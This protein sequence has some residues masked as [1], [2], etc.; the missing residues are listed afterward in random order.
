[1]SNKFTIELDITLADGGNSAGDVIELYGNQIRDDVN[2]TAWN[3]C[4]CNDQVQRE[5]FD[6][7]KLNGWNVTRSPEGNFQIKG[8]FA[9]NSISE[10]FVNQVFEE[11][12]D[13]FADWITVTQNGL[14]SRTG[15]RIGFNPY[16]LEWNITTK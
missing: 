11:Y 4:N 8:E 16:P 13:G 10:E 7:L 9:V 15:E 12:M 2:Q 6:D 1:M 5:K 3:L 14:Y